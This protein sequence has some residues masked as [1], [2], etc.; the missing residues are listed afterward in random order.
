MTGFFDVPRKK[1]TF[2]FEYTVSNQQKQDFFANFSKTCYRSW[3]KVFSWKK[4][5]KKQKNNKNKRFWLK[6]V[7]IDSKQKHPTALCEERN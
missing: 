3:N 7:V 4:R 1:Y 5:K 2:F 6:S